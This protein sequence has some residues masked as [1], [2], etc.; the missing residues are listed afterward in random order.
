MERIFFK[1]VSFVVSFVVRALEV[2]FPTSVGDGDAYDWCFHKC[3]FGIKEEGRRQR[4]E[5]KRFLN[6]K[7]SFN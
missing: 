6:S 5:G 1:V 2:N 7:C 3:C 4:A